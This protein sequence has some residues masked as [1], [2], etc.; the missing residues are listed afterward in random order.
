MTRMELKHPDASY[1]ITQTVQVEYD[2]K[3]N[4]ILIAGDNFEYRNHDGEGYIFQ[5]YEFEDLRNPFPP[6]PG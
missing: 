4:V 1:G 6:N 3:G 2:G 5:G